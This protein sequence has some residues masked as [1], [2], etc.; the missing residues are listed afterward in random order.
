[1]RFTGMCCDEFG[2]VP[3][4][5]QEKGREG[6]KGGVRSEMLFVSEQFYSVI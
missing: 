5:G 1:M 3:Q 4:T 2:N 6:G